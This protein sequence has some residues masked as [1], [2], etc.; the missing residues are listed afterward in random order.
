MASD[1]ME[2]KLPLR[3]RLDMRLHLLICAVCKRYVKQLQFLHDAVQRHAV[4][5]EKGVAPARS[6]LSNEAREKMKR[7]LQASPH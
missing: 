1:S 5:I 7:S 6:A 4:E 3:Q 2:R